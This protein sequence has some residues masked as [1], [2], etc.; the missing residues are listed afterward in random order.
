MKP[1]AI[2]RLAFVSLLLAFSTS[3]S[4]PAQACDCEP[5]EPEAIVVTFKQDLLVPAPRGRNRAVIDS[6]AVE[7][8][9]VAT[10]LARNLQM[11]AESSGQSVAMFPALAGVKLANEPLL[12]RSKAGAEACFDPDEDSE[13]YESPDF[14][15]S[16]P[17]DYTLLLD[18]VRQFL[19]V[20]GRMVVCP[21][22]WVSRGYPPCALIEGSGTGATAEIGTPETVGPLFLNAQKVIDF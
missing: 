3:L 15:I 9:C 11:A 18:L 1:S 2:N 13:G 7:A 14:N 21:L 4:A 19:D 12:I 5:G 17:D 8:A 20:G 16:V 22:C 10:A 6:A